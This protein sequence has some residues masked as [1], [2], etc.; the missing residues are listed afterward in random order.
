MHLE[1]P[2]TR[3]VL[4]AVLAVIIACVP[5][6]YGEAAEDAG[7]VRSDM[8]VALLP[9]DNFSN[10]PNAL[11]ATMPEI[12]RMLEENGMEVLNWESMV[13]FMCRLRI[14]STSVLSEE[15][16][17]KIGDHF[18]LK[19]I[20]IGAVTSFSG[21]DNPRFGVLARLINTDDGAIIWADHASATGEDFTGLLGL[22][23]VKT[24]DKLVPRVSRKLFETFQTSPPA[25]D[26]ESTYKVAVMPFQNKS[27]IRGSGMIATNLFLVEL[28]K[29]GMFVPFE[30]G[31]VR[32]SIVTNRILFRGELDYAN[33]N[34]FAET[35]GTDLIVVGSVDRY[36][37]GSGTKVVPEVALSARLLD[38]LSNRIVWYNSEELNGRSHISLFDWG[39][40]RSADLV[41]YRLVKDLVENITETPWH[42]ENDG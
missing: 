42:V 41:A 12:Q 17:K 16:I 32:E 36:I 5:F 37:E 9:F 14:R 23:T 27:D 33:I 11:P 10:N 35:L 7:A 40:L 31:F 8:R 6:S 25:R 38:A 30:Y 29:N 13:D 39:E 18:S 21:E 24:I 19:R 4:C 3:N 22:G 15:I 20:I 26:I 1:K 34:A 28:F 2:T